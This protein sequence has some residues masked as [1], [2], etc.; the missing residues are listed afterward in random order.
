MTFRVP[1]R[2]NL[3]P[4]TI[5]VTI[6][7]DGTGVANL[8]TTGSGS[9]LIRQVSVELP[10]APNGAG[11]ALRRDGV[12]ITPLIATGDAAVEPPPLPVSP[13][14]TVTVEWTGCTPGD[15]GTVLVFYDE[16]GVPA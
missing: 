16:I 13:G 12:L 8:A 4:R 6:G 7:A 10:T 9:I 15:Q 11:C 1:L 5:P 2:S 3:P 14:D